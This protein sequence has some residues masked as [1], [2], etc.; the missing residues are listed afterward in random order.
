MCVWLQE[1]FPWTHLFACRW[2]PFLAPFVNFPIIYRLWNW[3]SLNDIH[4]DT[5]VTT[6]KLWPVNCNF[7]IHDD[8]IKWKHTG[9]CEG[10]P[11]VTGGFPSQRAVTRS[12]DVFFDPRLKKRLSKQSRRRWLD[13]PSPSLWRHCDITQKTRVLIVQQNWEK[14]EQHRSAY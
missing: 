7:D 2:W 5:G 1:S 13:T 11:P 8:V 6:T 9:L 14:M 12:F 3:H 4:T 10:N